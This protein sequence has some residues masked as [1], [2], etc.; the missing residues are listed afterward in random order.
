[1]SIRS[2]TIQYFSQLPLESLPT[3]LHYIGTITVE[4]NCIYDSVTVYP[5]TSNDQ[6]SMPSKKTYM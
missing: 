4:A 3:V 5:N 2:P 6:S 1:M